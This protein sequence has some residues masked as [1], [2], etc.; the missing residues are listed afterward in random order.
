MPKKAKKPTEPKEKKEE[1]MLTLFEAASRLNVS[2][3]TIKLWI[4]HGKIK[5]EDV[6]GSAC[7][8]ESTIT[9]F[10]LTSGRLTARGPIYG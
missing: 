2:E 4:A 7:I 3:A 8:P 1:K 10:S 6:I 5:L 9:N